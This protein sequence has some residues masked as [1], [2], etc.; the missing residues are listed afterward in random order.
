MSMLNFN[1]SLLTVSKM[2]ETLRKMK[3]EIQNI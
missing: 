3:W 1:G 2:A